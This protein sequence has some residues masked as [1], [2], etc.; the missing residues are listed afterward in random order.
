[1]NIFN[2]TQW[3]MYHSTKNHPEKYETRCTSMPYVKDKNY[4]TSFSLSLVCMDEGTFH[5]VNVSHCMLTNDMSGVPYHLCALCC[6]SE[7][8][9]GVPLYALFVKSCPGLCYL[10]LLSENWIKH[11]IQLCLGVF[12][13]SVFTCLA[14][15]RF[16]IARR[17]SWGGSIGVASNAR[18]PSVRNLFPEQI[19]DTRGWIF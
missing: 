9:N 11:K 2:E 17:Q 6:V 5:I 19:S 7:R 13:V 14:D 8:L 3:E 18:R 16:F 10:L 15:L 1:M 12:A 4:S